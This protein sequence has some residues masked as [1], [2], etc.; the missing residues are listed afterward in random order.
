M[1]QARS[2]KAPPQPAARAAELLVVVVNYHARDYLLRCLAA[3]EAAPPGVPYRVVLVDNSPGDGA[4][5]AVRARF[6]AVEI[7]TNTENVGFG[8][9]CNQAL[10]A[11]REPYCL[12]LNPDAEVQPGALATLLAALKTNPRVA[13]VGPRLVYPD[14][15]YQHSAFRLPD[16]AQAFFGFFELVPLD[17]RWNGR[18]PPREG[19]RPRPVEHLLGACLLIRRAALDAV[20]LLDEA[21]FMYFEETDWCARALRAGWALWQ[22]PTAVVRHQSGGTTRS[23][24]EEMSLA[25]HRSQAHYYRKHHG[26]RGYLALKLI[27]VC[28]VAWRF[29]RSLIAALRRR[30]APE[31]LATRT[32]IYW[33]IVRA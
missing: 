3:L 21:F 20:G 12:L 5:E 30:I 18:Y 17:S 2:A 19:G 13:A 16:L 7:L 23:V 10:R 27:V 8:R 15:R 4:A 6:P 24:A 28:G 22:V 11:S 14:G 31:L 25:F 33:E 26:W 9:A 29:L 32:R 1:P